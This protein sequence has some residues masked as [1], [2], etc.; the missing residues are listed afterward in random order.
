MVVLS[1]TLFLKGKLVSYMDICNVCIVQHAVPDAGVRT[2]LRCSCHVLKEP[3]G[4][5][6]Y[7]KLN[8]GGYTIV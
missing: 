4:C 7:S 5:P 2:K 1:S 3:S 8:E 6:S